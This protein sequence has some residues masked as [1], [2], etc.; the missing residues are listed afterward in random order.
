MHASYMD[1]FLGVQNTPLLPRNI[2]DV[3][4][5][6]MNARGSAVNNSNHVVIYENV[7]GFF[8]YFMGARAWWMFKVCIYKGGAGHTYQPRGSS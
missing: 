4:T 5:F 7:P 6:Q 2:P 8:G 1:M 3:P